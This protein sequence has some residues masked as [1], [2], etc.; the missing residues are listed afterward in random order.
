[1][2]WFT[3]GKLNVTCAAGMSGGSWWRSATAIELTRAPSG[4]YASETLE[5]DTI[6][7]ASDAKAGP[8][9]L[10]F[11]PIH[12]PVSHASSC[13][14]HSICAG[15]QSAAHAYLMRKPEHW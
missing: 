9:L 14:S 12:A 8:N 11:C 6:K 13:A 5:L 3:H 4:L 1:M 2:S 7:A 15:T 10:H